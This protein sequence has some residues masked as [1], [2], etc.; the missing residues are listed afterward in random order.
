MVIFCLTKVILTLVEVSHR[1]DDVL[2]ET[3]CV[4]LLRIQFE[5][6]RGAFFPSIREYTH[7]YGMN[8]ER[9]KA[10]VC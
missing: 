3:D 6:Q 2:G 7:F 5:R 10:A 8:A 4:N 1:L 9:L